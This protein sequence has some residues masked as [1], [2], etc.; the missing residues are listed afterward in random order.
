[1][2]SWA[3]TKQINENVLPNANWVANWQS[4]KL[5]SSSI[6]LSSEHDHIKQ[7]STNP[8]Q[9]TLV[10]I[11][12]FPFPISFS[13]SLL[14]LCKWEKGRISIHKKRYLCRLGY[15]HKTRPHILLKVIGPLNKFLSNGKPKTQWVIL[16]LSAC[17]TSMFVLHSHATRSHFEKENPFF[18]AFGWAF[19]YI[20]KKRHFCWLSA[21]LVEKCFSA[22]STSLKPAPSPG[23]P[24][25]F[26]FFPACPREKPQKKREK[27]VSHSETNRPETMRSEF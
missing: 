7:V 19:S 14:L 3:S 10:A 20:Q 6:H 26:S 5:F 11:S 16:G 13:L 17:S 15:Q 12:H 21:T 4:S 24:S 25:V 8:T 27:N 22:I 2:I 18:L 23:A 1:M 9:E